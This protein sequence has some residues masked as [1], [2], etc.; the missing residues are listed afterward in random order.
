[1]KVYL[2]VVLSFVCLAVSARQVIYVNKASSATT[3]Y[4]TNW[5]TA[6]RELSQAL[7]D[8][9]AKTGT[10]AD[11]VQIWITK[12]TYKPTTGLSR[13]ATFA[14]PGNVWIVGSF[15]GTEVTGN[16]PRF[17]NNLTILSGDIGQAMTNKINDMRFPPP[18]YSPTNFAFDAGFLDNSYN[19][20]TVT[21][22]QNVLLQNV[23]IVNGNADGAVAIGITNAVADMMKPDTADHPGRAVRQLDQRV[24]GGGLFG[25]NCSVT[26]VQ[27]EFINNF[28]ALGGGAA[29]GEDHTFTAEQCAFLANYA[30][31]GGGGLFEL[32]ADSE[33]NKS[34]FYFNRSDTEA[35][36]AKF[37]SF[38]RNKKYEPTDREKALARLIGS[39]QS[40]APGIGLGDADDIAINR[41]GGMMASA[42]TSVIEKEL[43][44]TG[45]GLTVES[46]FSAAGAGLMAYGLAVNVLAA[47][48]PDGTAQEVIQT[49]HRYATIEGYTEMFQEQIARLAGVI[50]DAITS[51]SSREEQ[52]AQ[53]TKRLFSEAYGKETDSSLWQCKF[54]QNEARV[55]GAVAVS[56]ANV[57]FD[58]CMFQENSASLMAGA[59]FTT[60]LTVPKFVNSIFYKNTSENG[61]SAIANAVQSRAQ[62]VNCTFLQNSSSSV[63]GHAVGSML[64][65][66]VRI[67]N[68]IMWSNSMSGFAAGGAD[69]FSAT[70][71]NAGPSTYSSAGADKFQLVAITE[72]RNSCLQGLTNIVEGRDN[73]IPG[74]FSDR[75]GDDISFCFTLEGGAVNMGE[76]C[77]PGTKSRYGNISVYPGFSDD[78][79]PFAGSPTLDAGDLMIWALGAAG[80]G[81]REDYNRQSRVQYG[82]IDMGATEGSGYSA[83]LY[84][85]P[86]G[87]G[88]QNGSSWE[89]AMSSLS[90][91]TRAGSSEIWVAAGTYYPTAGSDRSASFFITNNMSI[92]GGFNGTETT[93]SERDPTNNVTILSGDIGTHGVDS[94]NSYRVIYCDNHVTYWTVIDGFT[95]TKGRGTDVAAGNSSGGAI[96]CYQASPRIQNCK[97]ID[98]LAKKGGAA[99]STGLEGPTFLNCQFLNNTATEDGGGAISSAARLQIENCSFIRNTAIEGG[100]VHLASSQYAYL[101]NCLFVSNSI[102]GNNFV[103]GSAIYANNGTCSIDNCTFYRNTATAPDASVSNNGAAFYG[104][105][106]GSR[107]IRNSVFWKN[108][109]TNASGSQLTLERQQIG[110][111]L[112]ASKYLS[113]NLIE[114]LTT[115]TDYN[116]IDSDPF[117]VN[118]TAG[119]FRPLSYS[120]L[121]DAGYTNGVNLNTDL[122]GNVRLMG[123]NIDMGA[124][125]LQGTATPVIAQVSKVRSC[126]PGGTIQS[127]VLSTGTNN[128]GFTS[129]QWEINRNDGLGFLTLTNDSVHSGATTATLTLTRPPV[130]LNGFS[131]RIRANGPA[132]QYVSSKL[133][134]NAAA[135]VV[136]V[137]ANATGNNSGTDWTNAYTSLQAAVGVPDSWDSYQ[138]YSVGTQILRNGVRYRALVTH[139]SS[140]ANAPPNANF[141]SEVLVD[142]CSQIWVATGTYY[143][144]NDVT[145][146]VTRYNVA[147]TNVVSYD[148]GLILTN[149]TTDLVSGSTNHIPG[150]NYKV[151]GV[152]DVVDKTTVGALRMRSSLRIYGG[153][154]GT[155][156][157]LAQRDWRVNPTIISGSIGNATDDSDNAANLFFNYGT[158]TGYQADSTALLDGF[159]LTKARDSAIY[160]LAAGPTIRNCT[161]LNNNGA[162]GGAIHNGQGGTPIFVNCS[163]LGNNAAEG[164]AI[165]NDSFPSTVSATNC[166]FSFNR[167]RFRGGA[168]F[169]GGTVNLVNCVA[170]NNTG[171]ISTGGLLTFGNAKILNSIFW[172]NLVVG[173]SLPTVERMQIERFY[174]TNSV[175]VSNSCVQGL[176]AYAGNGNTL[177]DPLFVNS[178]FADFRLDAAS[179]CVNGGN[180]TFIGNVSLDLAGNA[181]IYSNSVVDMGAYELQSAAM[182]PTAFFYNVPQ[183]LSSCS[184][185]GAATFSLSA[186]PD[187]TRSFVW[188]KLGSSGFTNLTTDSAY[189]ISSSSSNSTLTVLNTTAAMNGFQFRI[190]ELNSHYTSAPVSLNV[191]APSVIYVNA[192]NVNGAHTGGSWATAFADLSSALN[193]AGSCSEIWVA[194]GN[195]TNAQPLVMK[196]GVSIL[197]GFSGAETVREQRN[198]LLN[199]VYLRAV[200]DDVVQNLSLDQADHT[201]VLDGFTIQAP[202]GHYG[203]LNQYSSPTFRNCTFEKNAGYAAVYN[204]H[205]S[206][207][208]TDCVFRSNS[209]PSMINVDSSPRITGSTF[210]RNTFTGHG[211]IQNQ[212]SSATIDR[213]VFDNNSA[214]GGAGVY[215]DADSRTQISNSCFLRN[216][217]RTFRGGAIE[218]YSKGL[219]LLNC[220][221]TE[222]TALYE[223]GGVYLQQATA[224]IANC[225]FWKNSVSSASVYNIS[226]E[227]A[228][229]EVY[230]AGLSTVT[231]S[232]SCI[233]GLSI[234]TGNSNISYDP[235]FVNPVISD[236][237]LGDSSPAI[238]AGNSNA[239]SIVSL[240]L[241]G[242]ARAVG[243]VD[244]G[245]YER[246]SASSSGVQ[247]LSL[248]EYQAACSGRPVKFTV[249][250]GGAI[251]NI[252]WQMSTN[253]F[254]A[255]PTNDGIHSVVTAGNSSTLNIASAST[256]MNDRQY[257]F[258][259][260]SAN[261]TSAPVTMAVSASSV[262]YVKP[263]A[264]ASGVGTSWATAFNNLSQAVAIADSCTEIWVASGT[265]VFNAGSVQLKPGVRIYGGFAGT[266]TA[267]SQRNAQVNQSVLMAVASPI[268]DNDG[269]TQTVDA[270]TV[271]DGFTITAPFGPAIRNTFSSFS[272]QNC[273][274][275]NCA[276][277]LYNLSGANPAVSNCVFIGNKA[278]A[279]WNVASAPTFTDCQF[280]T[281]DTSRAGGAISNAF[282]APVFDRCAFIGNTSSLQGGAIYDD[283]QS[284]VTLRNCVLRNNMSYS[285]GGAIDHNG[286]MMTVLNSTIFR[287][288]A[289]SGGAGLRVASGVGYVANSI[290]W[291]NSVG[292]FIAGDNLL[293]AE[294]AQMRG[295][296]AILVVSN[297]CVQG[298][299]AYVGYNNIAYDPLFVDE[300]AN[301]LHL[302]AFSPAL[303]AGN[304]ALTASTLDLEK[305]NR[306]FGG[307]VDIGAYERQGAPSGAVRLYAAATVGSICAGHPMTF[308]LSGSNVIGSNFVWQV[309]VF[310][311]GTNYTTITNS[312]VYVVTVTSNSSTLLIPEV[313]VNLQYN[314]YRVV[315]VV[316][317]FVSSPFTFTASS[318][319][320]IRVKPDA[321]GAGNGSDWGNAFTN[322][323]DA[324]ANASGCTEI[325]VAAGTYSGATLNVTP[326]MQV[327]GGF[328]GTETSR[329]QRNI[330][331]HPTIIQQTIQTTTNYGTVDAG[332]VIDGFKFTGNGHIENIDGSPTIRNC[333]FQGLSVYA[334]NNI[335]SAPIVQSCSF[336][337]NTISAIRNSEAST[338]ISNC[339]FT[340]NSASNGAAILNSYSSPTIVD[341]SFYTNWAPSGAALWNYAS[342]PI[343]DRCVFK[344][345]LDGGAV[346]NAH[347]N[348]NP[349][350]SNS[351]FLYNTSSG[352]GGAI[353]HFGG[354]L[355]INNCTITLNTAAAA[356]GGVY[357]VAPFSVVN[358]ILWNNS[359]TLPDPVLTLEGYQIRAAGTT[360]TISNSCVQ[361]L[362]SYAG[363]N[364]IA[365]D[366]LM[367]DAANGD[368]HLGD[369]SPAINAGTVVASALDLERKPRTFGSTVDLGALE[370]QTNAL[371]VVQL[372]ASPLS[373][374][375]CVQR[376][377]T[378][379]ISGTNGSGSTF[380]WQ[381]FNGSTYVAVTND[382]QVTITASSSLSTMTVIP[383]SVYTKNYRVVISGS[384]FVPS[385]FTFASTQP[386]VLYVNP[387]AAASGVGNNWGAAFKTLPEALAVSD[388]CTEIWVAAGTN[389][390]G[391]GP[392]RLKSGV[393][394]YGGFAGTESS[395]SQ[396]N[397]TN[398]ISVLLGSQ[399]A[400]VVQ[401]GDGFTTVSRS[402]VLDGFTIKAQNSQVGIFNYG[403]QPTI[404]NCSFSGF[405]GPAIWND[406]SA[407]PLIDSCT[408]AT[409]D[410]SATG[411]S[412]VYNF[413]ASPVITNSLFIGNHGQFSGAIENNFAAT[414]IGNCRFVRNSADFKGGAIL[415]EGDSSTFIVNSIFQTNSSSN[416]GGAIQN[417]DASTTTINGCLF[418]GNFARQGGAVY[419]GSSGT[420]TVLNS[421]LYGNNASV[422]WG[423]IGQN[424]GQIL[425]RNS[426]LWRNRD[427][428]FTVNYEQAQVGTYGGTLSISNSC[429]ENL[430]AYAGYN[431]AQYDPLFVD[432]DAQNFRISAYS[433]VVNQG[434]SSA[435]LT[436]IPDLDNN[437]RVFGTNV[438]M[439]AYELQSA[440]AS[441]VVQLMATPVSQISC[442][443]RITRFTAS[444]LAAT[445]A[446]VQ[447][448]VYSN[449]QYVNITNGSTYTISTTTTNSTLTI[450]NTLASMAG[451]KVRIAI[452]GT[453]YVSAPAT[454][455]FGVTD[456]IY[457]KS[458]APAGGN[459]LTWATA[460]NNLASA[461]AFGDTCSEIWVAAGTYA[462][463][464]LEMKT[465]LAIYGGFNGTET[466]RGQRNY[467]SNIALLQGSGYLF[468]NYGGDTAIDR[469]AVLDGLY[470]TSTGTNGAAVMLNDQ[471]SPTIRNCTF[472][473]CTDGGIRNQ[474][475]SSPLIE[476]CTFTN[477][478]KQS[479]DSSYCSPVISQ[480][481]FL[482]NK[483]T[484]IENNNSSTSTVMNCTFAGNVS[485]TRAG[486]GILDNFAA[487]TTVG[488]CVFSNNIS[489]G[490]GAYAS[491]YSTNLIYNC[492]FRQNFATNDGGALRV[493]DGKMSLFNSTIVQNSAGFG[494]GLYYFASS[495][496]VDV[497]N[498]IF[499]NNTHE[500]LSYGVEAA[501]IYDAFGGVVAQSSI[502][503]GLDYNAGSG[504]LG[505]DPLF[506][507]LSGADLRLQSV[508]PGLNAGNNSAVTNIATDLLGAPRVSQVTVDMGAYET[509]SAPV[510]LTQKPISGS[511]STCVGGNFSF[512]V[513][514]PGVAP[515]PYAG[516]GVLW[517]LDTGSGFSDIISNATYRVST[518]ASGSTLD[519]VNATLAMNGYRVRFKLTATNL[520]NGATV[521]YVSPASTLSVS[522][523]NTVLYV[524][525]AASP[526]GNGLS[527]ATAFKDLQSAL[528]YSSC[529]SEVWV[530]GGTYYPT[531]GTDRFAGFRP[532][533]G[534]GLY[535]GFSGTETN[536]NQRN[537]TNNP[538]ILSGNIGDLGDGN[539]NSLNVV[540][541][542]QY[543]IVTNTIFDGF[544]VESGVRGLLLYRAEPSI[545]NCV[546]RNN[547]GSGALI[548]YGTPLFTSCSFL[549]NSSDSGGGVAAYAS[550]A[551]FQNCTFSGNSA[552]EGGGIYV[553]EG[554]PQFINCLISGNAA[555]GF[556]AGLEAV[557]ASPVLLNCTV[558]GNA[559]QSSFGGGGGVGGQVSLIAMTNCIVWNNSSL[560]SNLERAQYY[561]INGTNAVS[562]SCV[563]G[564]SS[565]AGNNNSAND[566][567]FVSGIDPTLAPSAVG[568][569]RLQE[570]SPLINAGNNSVVTA[571]TDL[572]GGLRS[573]GGTVD[574][575]AYELQ[576]TPSSSVVLSQDPASI[577]YCATASNYFHVVVSGTGLTYQWE[578]NLGSGFVN[579]AN[580]T[581]YSGAM[582]DTL[583]I[584][585]APT[586][587]NGATYRCFISSAGGCTFRSKRATLTL[588][589][590]RL[591]VN[592]AAAPGGDGL[593]WA[594]AFTNLNNA[595]AA[596]ADTCKLDIWVA[597]GT[598]PAPST[599]FR[600]RSHVGIYG[601]FNGT[602]TQL[603]Q[604]NWTT[605]KTI[606]TGTGNWTFYGDGQ[607]TA[608][609]STCIIDGCIVKDGTIAIFNFQNSS[610]LIANCIIRDNSGPGI[611]NVSSSPIL[612]N[613]LIEKNGSLS[614]QGGGMSVSGGSPKLT[615]CIFRANIASSGGAVDMAS[616]T[617]SINNCIFSGN[618]AATSGGAI[619]NSIGN[620]FIRSS[621]FTGNR[622]GNFAGGIVTGGSME[623]YNSILWNNMGGTATDET[624]QI[625]KVSSPAITVYATCFQGFN[626]LSYQARGNLDVDP[627]FYSGISPVSAPT[628]NGNFHLLDCSTLI[629]AGS[630]VYV[631]TI[632][633]DFDGYVRVY[634]TNVDMGAF[635][636]Q[637]AQSPITILTQP[638][639]LTYCSASSANSFTVSASGSELMYQWQVSDGTNGYVPVSGAFYS[640][641]TTTNL[642]I[643]GVTTA[644]NGYKFRCAIS[645]PSGCLVYS[646]NATLAVNNFRYYVNPALSTNGNGASWATAFNNLQS[647]MAAPKDSCGVEIWV[648]AGTNTA[649]STGF[650]LT[651]NTAIYGG[652]AGW[653]TALSERNWKT[654]LSLCR[655]NGTYVFRADSSSVAINR[656]ARLDGLIIE[657]S[658]SSSSSR[659][660]YAGSSFLSAE[661]TVYNCTFRSNTIGFEIQNSSPAISNCV[662]EYNGRDQNNI[663]ATAGGLYLRANCGPTLE[664]CLFRANDATS[665][666]GFRMSS[667][668]AA[669]LKN[670]VF[671]G[672][673]ATSSGGAISLNSAGSAILYNCTVSGNRSDNSA[674]GIEAV[675][676]TQIFNSIIFSNRTALGGLTNETAQISGTGVIV[677]NS[678]IQ[679]MTNAAYAGKNNTSSNPSFVL[680]LDPNTA[681]S[682]NG[683][684]HFT[685]CSP[686]IDAGSILYTAGATNDFENNLRLYGASV[687]IGAYEFQ[688]VSLQV[689]NNP[690]DQVGDKDVPIQFSV[691]ANYTNVTYQWQFSTG[692]NYTNL[693]NNA[694]FSG[695]TNATLVLTNETTSMHSNLFRCR[696]VY[697]SSCEAISSSARF[698][699]QETINDNP[700]NITLSATNVSESAAIGTTIG[701]FT[702]TDPDFQDATTLSLVSGTGSTDNASFTVV[703]NVLKTAATLNYEAK[704]AMSIRVR[705]T[706]LGGLTF[707]KVFTINVQNVN[708]EYPVVSGVV[709]VFAPEN[710]TNA[711]TTY[712]ATDADPGD[713]I[714]WSLSGTDASFFSINSSGLLRFITA[715]DYENPSDANHDNVYQLNIQARD[716][717]SHTTSVAIAVS[718]VDLYDGP[719]FT[720]TPVTNVA[721][722]DLYSYSLSASHPNN[723]PVTFSAPVLPSWLSFVYGDA[724][725][726]F[727]GSGASAQTDGTGTNAAF[728]YPQGLAINS[729]GVIYVGDNDRVRKVTPG[730]VVTTESLGSISPRDLAVGSDPNTYYVQDSFT[731]IKKVVSGT[732]AATYS[733]SPESLAVDSS[734]NMYF[735]RYAKIFKIDPSGVVS[736]VAGE[737]FG[738]DFADGVGSSARFNWTC[739]LATDNAGHLYVSDTYN[740]RIRKIDLASRTVSTFLGNGIPSS[741]DG[742]GT[743]A[744]IDTPMTLT[745]S[746]SGD[747]YVYEGASRKIR[748]ITAAGA[749]STYI[750]NGNFGYDNGPLD[751]STFSNVGGLDF[752]PAGKLYVTD[753][754]N[755]VIRRVQASSTP[756]LQGTAGEGNVGPHAVT[757]TVSDGTQ[758]T[759]QQFNILVQSLAVNVS[760][761]DFSG[762]NKS[763]M[764]NGIPGRNYRV[765]YST[766]LNTWIDLGPVSENPPGVFSFQDGASL[767]KTR[768]YR[769]MAQ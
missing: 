522:G 182:S 618:Y 508:S 189:V 676:T 636:A 751:Q 329:G 45:G 158:Q 97:F 61:F 602:E 1:M 720:S 58:A 343:V 194:K 196:S 293:T 265:N 89:N 702:A 207:I 681:P 126:D 139:D 722:I 416:V 660:L 48:L 17:A 119:D 69:V 205:S 467:Q 92:Y 532:V 600:L 210:S 383:T 564:L 607:T 482:D 601:G 662:F 258:I 576:S 701:T 116:N 510:G 463:S 468:N 604:R 175:S 282:A 331:A 18:I 452:N 402:G 632:S 719:I 447:W 342:S 763:L 643:S 134:L 233:Q 273:T 108:S 494:G 497:K 287:N 275:T 352:Y 26:M 236:Y 367:V 171:E 590:G 462:P 104:S 5:A 377:V 406:I 143:V 150:N 155:E 744:S 396:R 647:A 201:P 211:S 115:L 138:A 204:T 260:P 760:A 147:F 184:V 2:A 639:P 316:S 245:A 248:P 308:S 199:P 349:A 348:S 8:P 166:V 178:S 56:H 762:T 449:G 613:C 355:K 527:W 231:V 185:G 422:Q 670:C 567:R 148:N 176:S 757:L 330:A 173:G 341:S 271:V 548:T 518:N 524:N 672:N 588:Y 598:Y 59:A 739:Y 649:P 303:N 259:L 717:A 677:S 540:Q 580:D 686:L 167:A 365:Y 327:F 554:R 474:L 172:N 487:K 101:Y 574:L 478:K 243:V 533:P 353:G 414:A 439:G 47:T 519:I 419:H 699:Y 46:K 239:A 220:T 109:V 131:Y 535:G 741:S 393:Q 539:D 13:A 481:R 360:G 460:F 270:S 337:S 38:H 480:C 516:I 651:N 87:A 177:Y 477:N 227:R 560:G 36:A 500:T 362:S 579:V 634:D 174:V 35:G 268:F 668:G 697:S 340:A 471:A 302:G 489:V 388:E 491:E 40:K 704:T 395:R 475:G 587:L 103:F 153:F 407:S 679:N 435:A 411:F 77:R 351:S 28:A 695:V 694:I 597:A 759:N 280:L 3:E 654:N 429:L 297:S 391:S 428:S 229:L 730:G 32:E 703:S 277:A 300:S 485:Q 256:S 673:H 80:P 381:V 312:S 152:F 279:V 637:T 358:S 67:V 164:G 218:D 124:Y 586:N 99:Y 461:I 62:I 154:S 534:V 202:T 123:A 94:D 495:A 95:I 298:L 683:D 446:A 132:Y 324:F 209:C 758:S 354:T 616:G 559:A 54:V 224:N 409:N 394:V 238:N 526:G 434:N 190:I 378:F 555:S 317:G 25:T 336:I 444:G 382:S 398:N 299:S 627:Q 88:N 41:F 122:G 187:G 120:P 404:R 370:K 589:P 215:N 509:T 738:A 511:T 499:W 221:V 413:H 376:T 553:Q 392:I 614:G 426:I 356:G 732:V 10:A 323:N 389:F 272:L 364:N 561:N 12:G 479:I 430:S 674:G 55:G 550:T 42:A 310:G 536:R 765:E 546:V 51:D 563:E 496:S 624:A 688:S 214:D 687:D 729:G 112:G 506:I 544:I 611:E 228:Q 291:K 417:S 594:T 718:V 490:G 731:A 208:Y 125:E 736:D 246:Q 118:A 593:S 599:A 450:G 401:C 552:G 252:Q 678:C 768:F 603:A 514:G 345:N 625:Y 451:L 114:G 698:R 724:V 96:Q 253:G 257:R 645:K 405:T 346:F 156:T 52:E 623:V 254:V 350:F 657:N 754:G 66:E 596:A 488:N 387:A 295:D 170:A 7:L 453:S 284:T 433:P 661:I 146:A 335:R 200:N 191:T 73:I 706:D 566:P 642:T 159:T 15:A 225:I 93:L 23:I 373:Q 163:F 263:T 274:F 581:V 432:P 240:D 82:K 631:G 281:N 311:N 21:N 314:K 264:G 301:D 684:F 79:R 325:W 232:N 226:V 11:P 498:C 664:N 493:H 644:Q 294:A 113:R 472:A 203:V 505:F 197:G 321:T 605:N 436:I 44:G 635:E 403:A 713:S 136:Y 612:L 737:E 628:T 68:T 137:R 667:S 375:A 483:L 606:F 421:A 326:N 357:A 680:G 188:Q 617:L 562:Y 538:T 764:F 368:L 333:T 742:V 423:G 328:N 230:P 547:T 110:F 609:D 363:N 568:N 530:A 484:A 145:T 34:S 464:S 682:T 441:P 689:T 734:G 735:S 655:P 448:Q 517:Q 372:F 570:C 592:A 714:T 142:E 558:S 149:V 641:A 556:G 241:D 313:D 492:V 537:W 767:D 361:S 520:P 626:N 525:A 195:Y 445:M 60:T 442:E 531:V 565:L 725:G 19:V 14:I 75:P 151:L 390:A 466:K 296:N 693:T 266:E 577:T 111:G 235:L 244:M 621:T 234:F 278:G 750:G 338:F 583:V 219:T 575:G 267:W 81:P 761:F 746:S 584:T 569:H 715:K 753:I 4:G 418:V 408:F 183:P 410:P 671:T 105:S 217:A 656:S 573:F 726:T 72:I 168:I 470:L 503:Q 501:Q 332:T 162:N 251:T 37:I 127:F 397:W 371:G 86:G 630:N 20:V 728:Y 359:L 70:S 456:V 322:L 740:Y 160:N 130:S 578:V 344:G 465:G 165:Y 76:G 33:L 749:I 437:P 633:S 334:V 400:P 692:G 652:F 128:Y 255:V 727:V 30:P 133:V 193:I 369:Y 24:A 502:I 663:A 117:F 261:Y 186:P 304:N 129:Y 169:N 415:N 386:T 675:S 608:I 135:S 473:N 141:W 366:P 250:T 292:G 27:V 469:S 507:D 249:S 222:N 307:T 458:T 85:K 476:S 696:V 140:S 216:T 237:H 585:N 288:R 669:I 315:D 504:N 290:L 529:V 710:S 708:D 181:R 747:V 615:N 523:T 748:K 721:S 412:L 106:A 385:Y 306:V 440:A 212:S 285:T 545:R 347:T 384:G 622:A 648:A 705:A 619:D 666:G 53:A 50:N 223:S 57:N 549:G 242:N 98:N 659:G 319:T 420:C 685:P 521:Y 269:F 380:Q 582:T 443:G 49:I 425:V 102:A 318:Q 638:A 39:Y 766:N 629:N 247:L 455:N 309:N 424:S 157:N 198:W 161:F 9:R 752:N 305:T 90:A 144:S 91:A 289:V 665:G 262:L 22:A 486:A 180:S 339:V 513:Y 64:G 543:P 743:N 179:P 557:V 572:D 65:S 595:L 16:E 646:T 707:E 709:L 83:R 286:P 700:T 640:G 74:C 769:I 711:L 63:L 84:V 121:V 733:V 276:P 283:S 29:F 206:A 78:F 379:T 690:V 571:S 43:F 107:T 399:T 31:A 515:G 691:A 551:Q 610:P 755:R 723:L 213:C 620:I 512:T 427:E 650:L 454:V 459:G 756:T 591:Y 541:F 320:I 6:Y 192:A 71:D 457:V 431:N 745:V 716:T 528:F 658:R 438:D 712:T 100:A 542:T 653:E 374:S